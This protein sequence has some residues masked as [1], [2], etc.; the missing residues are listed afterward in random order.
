MDLLVVLEDGENYEERRRTAL[1]AFWDYERDRAPA[2]L[3]DGAVEINPLIYGRSE[4]LEEMSYG[5]AE[6][7][8][9]AAV[10]MKMPY[11]EFDLGFIPRYRAFLTGFIT[12]PRRTDPAMRKVIHAG[13]NELLRDGAIDP[14]IRED[15]EEGAKEYPERIDALRENYQLGRLFH[16]HVK[17]TPGFRDE[18]ETGDGTVIDTAMPERMDPEELYHEIA[19]VERGG[20]EISDTDQSTFAAFRPRD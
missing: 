8:Q 6:D 3:E 12:H 16:R 10:T 11:H 2:P 20:G 13:V 5:D 15:L 7:P 18:R 1:H 9:E 14:A 17:G 4:F 19:F